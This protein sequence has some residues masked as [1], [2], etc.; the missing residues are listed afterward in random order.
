MVKLAVINL[1]SLFKIFFRVIAIFLLA[2]IGVKFVKIVYNSAKTW[3]TDFEI[4]IIENNLNLAER[5]EE[6]TSSNINFKKVLVSE[7]ALFSGAEQEIVEKG[8]TEYE[9]G[10]GDIQNS[11]VE[12]KNK[13]IIQNQEE[14]QPQVD[15]NIEVETK[16]IAENNK[17]DVYTDT[18]KSVQIKNESNYSLTEAMVTPDISYSN[19]KEIMI[20]H[21]HTCESY[22]PTEN[23]N[24][25]A[26][27]N[28]RTTDLNYSVAR[29]GT[30]LTNHMQNKGYTVNHDTTY[31][32]YPAYT[33]SYNRSLSTV[34]S[35][36]NTHKDVD[37]VLDI[38][39]DAIRKW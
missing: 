21:T 38:H 8:D 25:I 34:T 36:L 14:P 9:V 20:F 28:Y 12:E 23:S 1:R 17:K 2:F 16:V 15:E 5:F 31:H 18:Y 27:G 35:L 22:T 33:G 3:K 13:D 24:Y 37:C 30:E 32:D 29:V 4:G 19:N 11:E 7:F 39:R 26:T 6:E 10:N